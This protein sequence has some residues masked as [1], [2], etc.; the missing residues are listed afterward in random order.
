MDSTQT[1]MTNRVLECGRLQRA[2]AGERQEAHRA[3]GVRER[4]GPEVVRDGGRMLRQRGRVDM[5]ERV[6][7]ADVQPLAAHGGHLVEQRLAHELV[8]EREP[9]DAAS[10]RHEQA[11][12]FGFVD[13]VDELVLGQIAQRVRKSKPKSRP[14]GHTAVST[15]G[16]V[17]QCL[18]PALDREADALGDFE[19]ESIEIAAPAGLVEQDVLLDELLHDLTEEERVAVRRLV[20]GADERAGGGAPPTACRRSP[21]SVR[22][23][24]PMSMVSTRWR[25]CSWASVAMQ[26]HRADS[27][28][29]GRCRRRGS[30]ARQLGGEVLEEHERRTI[31]PVQIVEQD[32]DGEARRGGRTRRA[33]S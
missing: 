24:A 30:A 20:E 25:W 27:A 2:L 4:T 12:S 13:R 18:Q 28:S 9:H 32:Q 1:K 3:L 6:G 10:T 29:S 22:S 31:G 21:T 26:W 16:V 14:I 19:V 23:S 33:H 15:A 7:D 8:C 11:G 17:L 5:L